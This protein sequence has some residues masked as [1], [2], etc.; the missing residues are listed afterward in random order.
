MV[1]LDTVVL[2]WTTADATISVG[3]TG[4]GLTS[5]WTTNRWFR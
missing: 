3:A 1:V 5:W 2:R 4:L